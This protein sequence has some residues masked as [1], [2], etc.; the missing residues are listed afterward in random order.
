MKRIVIA[1]VL[2]AAM[3]IADHVIEIPWFIS[4]PMFA[5]PYLICGYDVLLAAFKNIA[6]GQ[7]FDER[8]LMMVATLSCCSTRR[9]SFSR[10]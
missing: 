4:L 9:V 10:E 5:V 7:F 1:A 3:M 6:H 8:F 2:F